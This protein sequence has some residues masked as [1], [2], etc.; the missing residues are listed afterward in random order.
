M[1]IDFTSKDKMVDVDKL[2]WSLHVMLL[3]LVSASS[4]SKA[5]IGL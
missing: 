1:L 5:K 2:N 3:L 4:L